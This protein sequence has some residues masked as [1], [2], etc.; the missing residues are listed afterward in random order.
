MRVVLATQCADLESE[1]V[2][3][4]ARHAAARQ[5]IMHLQ[6]ALEHQEQCTR[7]LQREF[8]ARSGQFLTVQGEQPKP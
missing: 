3:L 8:F 7:E 5:E 4:R 6:R 2:L 1:N